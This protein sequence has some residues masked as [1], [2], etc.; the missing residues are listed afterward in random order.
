MLIATVVIVV[1]WMYGSLWWL[2]RCPWLAP[3]KQTVGS[4]KLLWVLVGCFG[5]ASYASVVFAIATYGGGD[6]G[7]MGIC[8]MAGG[9]IS[10]VLAVFTIGGY[11]VELYNF[12]PERNKP[13]M[14]WV[15]CF[16]HRVYLADYTYKSYPFGKLAFW[17]WLCDFTSGFWG[18]IDDKITDPRG[19]VEYRYVIKVG[20]EE[21]QPEEWGQAKDQAVELFEKGIKEIALSAK[22]PVEVFRR[23]HVLRDWWSGDREPD[24]EWKMPSGVKFELQKLVYTPIGATFTVV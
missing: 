4:P 17:L 14:G 22:D 3:E 7:L 19:K 15:A 1:L 23:L 5:T 21:V 24:E 6:P 12:W 11:V 20:D 9:Y 13:K 10:L 18:P 2:A 8:W 16:K